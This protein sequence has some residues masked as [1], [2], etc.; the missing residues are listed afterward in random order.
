MKR[1]RLFRRLFLTYLT[2]TLLSL[3]VISWLATQRFRHFYLQ[4]TVEYLRTVAHLTELQIGPDFSPLFISELDS[5]C[6]TLGSVTSARTTLIDRD[7]TV[8]GD[9]REDP[10]LMEN[11]ADRLEFRDAIKKGEGISTRYSPTLKQRMMYLAVPLTLRDDVVGVVR[12]SVPVTAID[13]QLRSVHGWIALAAIIVAILTIVIGF[14]AA[15]SITAPLKEMQRGAQRFARGDLGFRLPVPATEELESLALALNQMATELHDRINRITEQRNELDTVLSSMVEGVIAFDKDGRV[16]NLNQ[17]AANILGIS[18]AV[19]RGRT[20]R[21]VIRN[22][23]LQQCIARVLERQETQES[24]IVLSDNLYLQTHGAVLYD[25][26]NNP[27]G[28]VVVLNDITRIKHLEHV[29][30]DFVA[31]VSHELRTPVTAIKGFVE[32]LQ[33]GAIHDPESAIRFLGII[34]A[35]IDRLNAIVGDLLTL[36]RIETAADLH[37]VTLIPGSVNEVVRAAIENCSAEASEKSIKLEVAMSGNIMALIDSAQL[38]KAVVNLL[39]NAIRYSE[40]GSTVTIRIE[41]VAG[42][43]VISVQ[44]HGC[45]ISEEHLPRIFERF[46]RVDNDRSRKLGGTGLGLAIV[47]HIALAHQGRVS[48]Q[49]QPGKGSTFRVHLPTSE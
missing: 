46:Y 16:I 30:R 10:H 15:R 45:G 40:P 49:S 20:L 32:T 19:S 23:D 18:T 6:K 31:N 14:A 42:E 43:I 7:G 48:V 9:S 4:Q 21:E 26:H 17:A 12:I 25:A 47:K 5:L 44:D 3:L 41:K 34:G 33:E 36:S 39:T 13:Q 2:V 22:A 24:E 29:R 28:A 37:A 35:H 38:E 8:L 27:V 1:P 11:H